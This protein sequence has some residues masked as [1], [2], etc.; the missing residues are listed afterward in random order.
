MATTIMIIRHAEKPAGEVAGVTAEGA[1]NTEELTVRGWQRSGALVR[2]FAPT[3][4]ALSDNRLVTPKFVFA[5][6]NAPHSKSLRPQHTVAALGEQLQLPLNTSHLKGDEEALVEEVLTKNGPVLIAW[7][8]EAI[9]QIVNR[10]TENATSCPQ[11]WPD[12][13]FDLVWLLDQPAPA[14]AWTFDQVPQLLLPG[15]SNMPIDF[16]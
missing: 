5:A 2:F 10:I 1:Q 16:A 15:D 6:G 3:T 9:P 12:E 8:H 7:E 11:K 14:A 13:R 4:G